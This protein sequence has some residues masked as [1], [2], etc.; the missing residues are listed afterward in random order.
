MHQ[1]HATACCTNPSAC[2]AECLQG[3]YARSPCSE[4]IKGTKVCAPHSC[5]MTQQLSV[6]TSSL[7]TG[8]YV[9]ANPHSPAVCVL[10]CCSSRCAARAHASVAVAAADRAGLPAA[11]ASHCNAQALCARCVRTQVWAA[12]AAMAPA[13]CKATAVARAAAAASAG[14]PN[15]AGNCQ[16]STCCGPAAAETRP[17]PH[18]G[19]GCSQAGCCHANVEHS[20]LDLSVLRK[21]QATEP[22]VPEGL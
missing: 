9:G 17:S 6:Q 14:A 8:C 3:S 4:K 13:A 7:T 5:L 11:P 22:S 1:W 10:R 20:Q 15:A 18:A 21:A 16:Q 12:A 2:A 19:D